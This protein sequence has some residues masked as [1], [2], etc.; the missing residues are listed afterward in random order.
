MDWTH[1]TLTVDAQDLDAACDIA[2]MAGANGIYAEDYRHLEE[3]TFEITHCSLID[4]AL[5]A[6]DRSKG[7]V[8]LYLPPDENPAQT[9]AFLA[10]RFDECGIGCE[11]AVGT[12]CDADWENNWK[13]Y[14]KPLAVGEK[15]LVCPVWEEP[16]DAQGRKVLLIE[17]GNAFGT[18]TH[19]TTAQCLKSLER[20]VFPGAKVLDIGCGSGILSLASLLLGAGSV[21]AVDL[22]ADAVETAKHNAALNGFSPPAFS[23]VKGNLAESVEGT[24]DIVAANIAADPVIALCADIGGLLKA[25]GTFI[26]AGII[27]HRKADVLHALN[28]NGLEAAQINEQSDWLCF[29][30]RLK[31]EVK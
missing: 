20:L 17:P 27:S 14:F 1:I 9:A 30:C 8:H 18:G 4:E 25:S 29:E 13:A 12:C 23:A 19:E 7:I 3:E 5:L 28:E 31:P 26:A 22:S 16:G 21:L 10:A 15:L 2:L 6:K 24:F 11:T